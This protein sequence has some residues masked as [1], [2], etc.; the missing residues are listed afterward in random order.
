M[1]DARVLAICGCTNAGKTTMARAFQK[2]VSP[3]E[4]WLI[5][6]SGVLDMRE[7]QNRFSEIHIRLLEKNEQILVD[8]CGRQIEVS[9]V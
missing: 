4:G 5:G 6:V 9:F 2:M 8:G 3:R 1:G 7:A